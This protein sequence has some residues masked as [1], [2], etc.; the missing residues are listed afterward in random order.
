M[1]IAEID[2]L[3]GGLLGRRPT[4]AQQQQIVRMLADHPPEQIRAAVD[5]AAARDARSLT[6]VAAILRNNAGRPAS[7]NGHAVKPERRYFVAEPE[8]Q[9]PLTPEEI[10]HFKQAV[11]AIRNGGAS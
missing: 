5:A 3:I 1:T 10:A 11:A 6:Y 2:E 9:T 7:P 8:E 4:K